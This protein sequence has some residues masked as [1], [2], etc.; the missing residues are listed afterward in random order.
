MWKKV[1]IG[2]LAIALFGGVY[3]YFFIYHKSHPDYENLDADLSISAEQLF[4]Q[5]KDE[6]KASLY[7]GKIL[8]INGL[9][10]DIENNDSLMTLVFVYEEGM[11]GAEGVR[12]TF[13]PQYN[14]KVSRLD[15]NSEVSIKAYCAGYNETDVILEKASLIDQ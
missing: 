15:L 4:D 3:T 8:E 6:G 1:I 14:Q 2:I 5:C 10:H 7:T 12:V 13:L 9:A 11:F